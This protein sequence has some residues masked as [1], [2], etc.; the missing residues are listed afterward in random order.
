MVAGRYNYR[1]K[2]LKEKVDSENECQKETK[3]IGN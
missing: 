1:T 3:I 2:N